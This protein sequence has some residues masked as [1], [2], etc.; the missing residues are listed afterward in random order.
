MIDNHHYTCANSTGVCEEIKYVYGGFVTI[1]GSYRGGRAY[2]IVLKDGKSIEDAFDEMLY[3]EDVNTIDNNSKKYL[4]IWYSRNMINYTDYLEDTVWCNNRNIIDFG[5]YNP[6]GGKINSTIYFESYTDTSNLPCKN[7]TDQFTVSKEKG[8][9]AL[10]YPTAFLTK[11]EYDM[12]LFNSKSPLSDGYSY[13]T[14]SPLFINSTQSYIHFAIS[15]NTTPTG[16]SGYIRPA[17]S[18]RPGIEFTIGDGSATN[19]YVIALD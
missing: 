11:Q 19:P 15:N 8:N 1:S 5:P 18:L 4:D 2:F 10:K 13:W 17:I 7:M 3:N 12:S 6:N 16:Y 14:M 9:G